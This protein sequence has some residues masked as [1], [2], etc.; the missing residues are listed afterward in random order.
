M[1]LRPCRC[2]TKIVSLYFFILFFS[3]FVVNFL[4]LILAKKN[5]SSSVRNIWVSGLSSITK[6]TDLK[7]LFSK[8]GK[9]IIAYYVLVFNYYYL[10][11]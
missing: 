3:K 6:A 1:I 5:N 2:Q 10:I 8:Y 9:V 4:K 7:Q 11:K